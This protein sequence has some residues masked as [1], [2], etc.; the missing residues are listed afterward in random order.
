MT[1]AQFE[2]TTHR[3]L[4]SFQQDLKDFLHVVCD[5]LDLEDD[6]R[7]AAVGA[8]LYALAPGDVIPDST[9]PLGYVDDALALRIVLGEVAARAPARFAS[10]EDR[11]P[12]MA[13]SLNADLDAARAFLDDVYEPF[14]ARI[15][16]SKKL[17]FKG[18]KVADAL[19]DPQWLDDEINLVALKLDF[20]P[21]DVNAAVKRVATLLPT[22]R[23]KLAPRK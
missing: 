10:Y 11:I 19:T 7:E 18:K 9:G 13:Q 20:K 12:E 3:W 6:L 16:G 22:F 5:D 17:E 21:A 2:T 14:R 23:S 8:V 4:T 1:T 15:L